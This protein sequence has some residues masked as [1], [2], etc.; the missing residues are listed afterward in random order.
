MPSFDLRGIRAGKY[1]NTAGTVSYENPTDV[2]DAMSA[3][4]DLKFAEGRLY[5]ESKLAEYIK[6]ATG[7]T[8]SLAVKY[9]KKAA[10]AMLYGCTTDTSK[11]N[12]K[13]SA[14]DVANYVGVGFYAPDK[15]DG[16]TKYTCVWV[17]KALFG[18]PSM[19]YQTKGEN[20]Q[21]N[22]PTT[23]GEFLAD[24]SENELLLE[25]ETVDSAA[26]AVTWIKGKLGETQ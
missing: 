14:K 3:Q 11:E 12:I 10:Q 5:A 2:G 4:L 22:T 8:I 26:D 16:V 19:A 24:D 21:F 9:I 13:F 1:K 23:T 17:P 25:T 20:I 15:V 7:G 6:L 18:P